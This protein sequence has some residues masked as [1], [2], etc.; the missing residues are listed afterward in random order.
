MAPRQIWVNKMPWSLRLAA[1]LS[2]L[3]ADQLIEARL[4]LS[5]GTAVVVSD[6]SHRDLFWAIRGAG[7]NFGFVTEMKYKI[8]DVGPETTWS[9]Q[10][11]TFG[12]D[13]LEQVF[14]V[15]NRLRETQPADM[16]HWAFA[17]KSDFD[18]VHV[19]YV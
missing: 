6:D 7:H 11:Y 8:Y 12:H 17:M 2:R 4:V 5:N 19:S 14:E 3:A 13:K 15:S 9:Y 18:P 10:S 1:N 16:I